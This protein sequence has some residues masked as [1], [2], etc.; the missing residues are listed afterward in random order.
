[1]DYVN[2][3]KYYLNR[4]QTLIQ[5]D[6]NDNKKLNE[7]LTSIQNH[8]QKNKGFFNPT[9]FL[10]GLCGYHTFII[11]QKKMVLHEFEKKAIPHMATCLGVGLAAGLIVGS[12]FGNSFKNSRRY[13]KLENELSYKLNKK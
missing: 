7:Y 5:R 9:F 4:M 13:S 6:W 8:K 3:N 1:M 2:G 11:Y 10:L 12:I